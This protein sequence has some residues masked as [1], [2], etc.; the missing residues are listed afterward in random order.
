MKRT[1]LFPLTLFIFFCNA[2]A[3]EGWTLL[4]STL[5]YAVWD[6]YFL[7]DQ[8]GFACGLNS[9]IL[10]TEDGGDTW[11]VRAQVPNGPG[12]R[13]IAF[14]TDQVGFIGG[15]NGNTARTTD[16][17][18]TWTYANIGHPIGAKEVQFVTDAIGYMGGSA[19]SLYKTTDAGLTWNALPVALDNVLT[20][21]FFSES[22]GWLNG[23]EDSEVLHTVDG[24]STYD[25]IS[26]GGTHFD[27]GGIA[28]PGNGAIGY[29]ATTDSIYRTTDHG[30]TWSPLYTAVI[31]PTDIFFLSPDTGIVVGN[32]GMA[33]VT[34]DGIHFTAYEFPEMLSI[35]GCWITPSGVAFVCGSDGHI[36]RKE[37]GSIA[38]GVTVGT[39]DEADF[40]VSSADGRTEFF[41]SAATMDRSLTVLDASGRMVH[42]ER[43]NGTHLVWDAPLAPGIY[44]AV[45]Q[46]AAVRHAR[47][48]LV[49]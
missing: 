13:D 29:A 15:V 45:V 24:G 32:F 42:Q 27:I 38:T 2:R 17:G 31:Q 33:A 48:F 37:L 49:R 30:Q 22:E 10:A 41:L 8:H 20:M 26:C 9:T 40:R 36:Y 7:D 5:T 11:T 44:I 6:V 46:D 43:A 23:S 12:L 4:N 14:A 19:D 3:Q 1:L 28:F 18:T 25:V 34:T 21:Q 47:R 39:S 16:G 35:R